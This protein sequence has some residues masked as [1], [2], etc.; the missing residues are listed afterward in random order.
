[1]KKM[2]PKSTVIYMVW[3]G[4]AYSGVCSMEIDC[5]KPVVNVWMRVVLELIL[6]KEDHDADESLP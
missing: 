3:F 6:G 2:P 5:V 4:I 1:M